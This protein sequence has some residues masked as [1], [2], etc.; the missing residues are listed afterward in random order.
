MTMPVSTELL[1]AV[2]SL[3]HESRTQLQQTINHAMVNIL[4]G[5]TLDC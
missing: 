2:R 5:W 1:S 4:G 3:L